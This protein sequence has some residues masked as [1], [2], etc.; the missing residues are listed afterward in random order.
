VSAVLERTRGES[1]V[2]LLFA[3]TLPSY[4]H[5]VTSRVAWSRA[6]R[7]RVETTS[8]MQGPMISVYNDVF[9][10]QSNDLTFPAIYFAPS[11]GGGSVTD[12]PHPSCL[13]RGTSAG[14]E[15]CRASHDVREANA[16][17]RGYSSS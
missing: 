2:A 10:G 15:R 13:H 7:S 1:G 6:R 12:P 5:G 14:V 3:L 17:E 11:G 16:R 9:A 8:K 4:R